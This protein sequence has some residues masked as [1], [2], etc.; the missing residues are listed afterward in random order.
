LDRSRAIVD[1]ARVP[2]A[3]ETLVPH[4]RATI[5]VDRFI[6]ERPLSGLQWRVLLLCFAIVLLDGWD[7]AAIGFVAPAIM[8]EWGI[9][10][11]LFGPVL[12]AAMFGLAAGALLAGPV[13]DR[14]G[15]KAVL[16]ASVVA[17]GTF[18]LLCGFAHDVVELTVLRFLTGLGLG[19]AMP[20]TTTLVSEYVPAR[21][22]AFLLTLMFTGFTLGSGLGGFGAAWLIPHFGWR[23]VLVAGGILPL[24][25]AVALPAALPES[26]RFLVL[27]GGNLTRVARI[28]TRMGGVAVSPNAT[29]VIAE[30]KVEAHRSVRSLLCAGYAGVTARLWLTYFMGLVIIYLLTGWLPTLMRDAGF[31]IERAAL[32]TGIFQIGGSLG[33]VAIGWVMDRLNRRLVVSAS[34]AIGATC[35][36]MLGRI[37]LTPVLFATVLLL[38]GLFL[39]GAQTGMN[40]LAPMSYPTAMRATGASWM[41]G[42]GR[43]GGI[44][45]SLIGGPLLAMGL[46]GANLFSLLAIPAAIAAVA[47]TAGT[48]RTAGHDPLVAPALH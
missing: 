48:R 36:L 19:A 38:A 29:F 21:S 28:L 20:N 10:K 32:I 37:D 33:S 42:I 18:S 41:L 27:R 5:D 16:I 46:T 12:S 6:D 26:V 7:T 39:S 24:I 25:L 43:C 4:S 23:S 1:L 35:V 22:K 45:G 40:A 14:I 13:S 11:A 9:A 30:P 15:R 2:V 47:L 34:Y 17:F 3:K 8:S 44:T 31:S